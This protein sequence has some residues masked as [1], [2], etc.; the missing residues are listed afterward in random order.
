MESNAIPPSTNAR[1][2]TFFRLWHPNEHPPPS[3][4][5]RTYRTSTAVFPLCPVPVGMAKTA[6]ASGRRAV[7]KPPRHPPPQDVP[8]YGSKQNLSGARPT[9][10]APLSGRF[11]ALWV[12]FGER[13]IFRRR[14]TRFPPSKPYHCRE[15]SVA[16]SLEVPIL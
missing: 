5:P 11:S 13:Q 1:K 8:S 2:T 15:P 3:V 14:T 7:V 4:C 9:L 10:N 6:P 16:L 12:S